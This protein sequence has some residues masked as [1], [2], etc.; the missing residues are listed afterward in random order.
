MRGRH[1]PTEFQPPASIVQDYNKKGIMARK[2]VATHCFF[3]PLDAG[4][5]SSVSGNMPFY[6]F[7]V[8]ERPVYTRLCFRYTNPNF[9][10]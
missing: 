6:G 10:S 4:T 1:K 9:P 7:F 3:Y 2:F 8:R 5:V